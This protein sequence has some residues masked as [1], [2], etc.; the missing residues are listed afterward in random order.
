MLCETYAGD[1]YFILLIWLHWA[2]VAVL[3]LLVAVCSLLFVVASLVA[4]YRL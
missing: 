2:L 1:N 3:V 4:E